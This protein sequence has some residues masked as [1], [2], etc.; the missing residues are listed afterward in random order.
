MN[1]YMVSLSLSLSRVLSFVDL[2]LGRVCAFCVRFFRGFCFDLR[3][4]YLF[5]LHTNTH[6]LCT[7]HS[8]RSGA[9][10]TNEEPNANT[11][12]WY[13]HHLNGEK[14]YDFWYSCGIYCLLYK[15]LEWMNKKCLARYCGLMKQWRNMFANIFAF[16]YWKWVGFVLIWLQM[17]L[18]RL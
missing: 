5:G 18:S 6:L 17:L 15:V 11:Q 7:N 8:T 4:I 14:L 3:Y 13:Q 16:D 1:V 12:F 10:V 9:S 2:R